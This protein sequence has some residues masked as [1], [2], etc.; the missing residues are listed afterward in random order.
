M[1]AL[2]INAIDPR[3]VAGGSPG[4][5]A[6]AWGLVAVSTEPSA[7]MSALIVAIAERRDRQAFTCLFNHFAP[8][9]KAYL[10]RMGTVSEAAEELAQETLLTVW[11]RAEVF[12]PDRAAASTWIFAIARNLRIDLARRERR[13][14]P[15]EDLTVGEMV[16]PDANLQAAQ[17]EVRIRAAIAT[18]PVEQSEVV[19]LAF[20]SDKAHAEIADDLSLPLGTVKSRIRLAMAKLR[21]LLEETS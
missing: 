13:P 1:H 6:R 4:R 21:A 10:L 2:A 12:N 9:V 3:F 20:F 16:R 15:G 17:D 8:R 14:L 5:S 19:R 7:D 18:L 11:R